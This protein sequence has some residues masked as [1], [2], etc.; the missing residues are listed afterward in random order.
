M[1]SPEQQVLEYIQINHKN[2]IEGLS[3]ES[4]ITESMNLL[5]S[6]TLAEENIIGG[7]INK[8]FFT[9]LPENKEGETL[10]VLTSIANKH[11]PSK[12]QKEQLENSLSQ[13]MNKLESNTVVLTKELS[14]QLAIILKEIFRKIKKKSKFKNFE[15]LIEKTKN[16]LPNNN[17]DD[18]LKKYKV[19][20]STKNLNT[21][22]SYNSE[23]GNNFKKN[24]SINSSESFISTTTDLSFKPQKSAGDTNQ[25]LYKF[26]EFK[27]DKNSQIPVEMIILMR[28]FNMVKKLRLTINKDYNTNYNEENENS[29]EYFID[30]NDIKNNIIILLNLPWLFQSLVDLEVDLSNDNLIDS[31]INLYRYSLECFAKL[32]HKDIKITTYQ[33]NP[34]YKRNYESAQKSIFS[35]YFLEDEEILFDKN[36]VSMLNNT[37]N[38]SIYPNLNKTFSIDNNNRNNNS[39]EGVDVIHNNLKEF[40]KKYLFLLEM[41]IIYGYFI[42]NMKTIIKTKFI[43]PTNLG[44]EIYEMLKRQKIYINDFHFLSFLTNTNIIY[45]TIDFNSLDNQTFEKLLSFLNQNQN[46][47]VCNLS[48]FPTEEY[49]KTELLFKIL[50][51][52][53]ENFK[54][55]RNK[56]NKLSFNPNIVLD[57]KGNEDIDNYLLRKLSEYFEKNMKKFFYFLTIKTC[58]TEL[59]LI[60]D[61]PTILIKNGY[62]NNV[63]MKFFLD[64]FIFIDSSLNNIKTLSLNSENFVFDSRKY[65]I[66]N[67]FCDKLSFYLKKEH[68][69]TNLTFQVKFYNIRKIYRF[70]PYNLSNLSIGSLDYETFNCLVDY[71]TSSDYSIRTKLY[72]LKVS[73]NNSVVD[74]NKD[75][76][77]ETII[78][79][80][81]EFPKGLSEISLYTYLIISYEQL[82]NLLI[83]SNYSTLLNIFIQFSIKSFI[84]YKEF[85]NKL[86][87]DINQKEKI[88]RIDNFIDLYAIHRSKNITTNLINLMMHL[89]EK[90]KDFMQYNIYTNIEKFL[91]NKEKKKVI[92]QFK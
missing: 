55:K 15:E 1:T 19:N 36:S 49:F 18:I 60:F 12:E 79:L 50:Q 44:D 73:L 24:I 27:E 16:F 41:I 53:D 59:S 75:K 34:L 88:I 81:A 33:N 85:E 64:L 68:K 83:K 25:L 45:S 43:M 57:L 91:C 11:K 14:E 78:R 82:Y 35:Q 3:A 58:I 22:T 71:L 4:H 86:E 40:I 90:N 7:E 70:I 87:Y 31:E 63:L 69:L 30:H 8:F 74:I 66:L 13:I 37:L 67:D 6:L 92:I 28:K 9:I 5:N 23:V 39:T 10:K 61:I 76:I 2:K 21:Y 72:K 65:P 84:K 89:G 48:F 26:R 80:F 52:C 42:R 62:Y 32:I 20:P 29:Q 77:Y 46:I 17:Q 51:N 56:K 38:Y 54:L 47:S